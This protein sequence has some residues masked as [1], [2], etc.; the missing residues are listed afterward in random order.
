V[1]STDVDVKFHSVKCYLATNDSWTEKLITWNNKPDTAS[2]IDITKIP[3]SQSWIEFDITSEVETEISVD[4]SISLVLLKIEHG[5]PGYTFHSKEAIEEQDHPM[6]FITPMD[7]TSYTISASAGQGGSINPEGE[8]SVFTGFNQSFNIEP[9]SGYTLE[10]VMVDNTSQGSLREYT[11]SNVSEDH[12]IDATFTKIPTY[13]ITAI[14]GDGGSIN[15]EGEMTVYEGDSLHFII[16]PEN[17]YIIA[18][19]LVDDNSIGA[20]SDYTFQNI[21]SGHS[22][23]AVFTPLS[24][25]MDMDSDN[26]FTLYPN[27]AKDKIIISSAHD[28]FDVDVYSIGGTLIK[29]FR[30]IVNQKIISTG[31]FREE[32]LYIIKISTDEVVEIKKL[33]IQE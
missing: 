21:S 22:I 11:F 15:P 26:N 23:E 27:P 9:D 8:I 32:G 24:G 13:T 20:V 4:G 16:E 6:L 3:G 18:D 19:V 30:N 7:V 10:D 5:N 1:K 29:S 12:T 17:D 14:A 31:Q 28:E 2:L 33:I 25:S